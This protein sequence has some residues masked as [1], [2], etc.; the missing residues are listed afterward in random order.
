MLLRGP[1]EGREHYLP[2]L[3]TC[4]GEVRRRGLEPCLLLHEG[5]R[6]VELAGRI[7]EGLGEPIRVVQRADPLELKAIIGACD[8]VVGSRYHGLVSALSQG[9]P[10]IG[11]AWSHKYRYL[12]EDFGWAGYLVELPADTAKLAG[13][14]GSFCDPK[15]REKARNHLLEGNARVKRDTE[16]MWTEVVELLKGEAS[17]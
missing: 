13:L 1:V 14:I 5:E 8:F 2:F 10:A 15:E 6:D 12:F 17:R 7:R 3:R 9:V 11:A 16:S 4:I